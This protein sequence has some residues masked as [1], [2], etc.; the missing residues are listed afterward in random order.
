MEVTQ[1]LST[2]SADAIACR[3]MVLSTHNEKFKKLHDLELETSVL[4]FMVVSVKSDMNVIFAYLFR[5]L[6]VVSL[7]L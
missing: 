2:G 5:L 7:S 6:A 1:G 3:K 4:D